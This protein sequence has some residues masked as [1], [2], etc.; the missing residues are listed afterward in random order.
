VPAPAPVPPAPA[1][2][3]PD[4]KLWKQVWS[5]DFDNCPNGRPDPTT[6]GFEHGYVRNKEQQYYQKDNAECDK[7]NLVI[8]AKREQP[9]SGEKGDY[10]SSSLTSENKKVFK[11]GRYEMRAK[12]PVDKGA[13]P[14]FWAR[15]ADTKLEWPSDGE[16]DIMEYYKNTVLANFVYGNQDNTAVW[17]SAKFAL[18]N[19]EWAKE[20]HVWAMEWDAEE[21]RL[22]VDDQL[23]NRQKVAVADDTGHANPW[24]EF[25][26]YLMVNL[27]IGGEN[28]GDPSDT[29]FPLKLYVDYISVYKRMHGT[30]LVVT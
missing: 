6:W 18:P 9:A 24:R 16:I 29:D 26:V 2:S 8:T 28:G 22:F 12:I 20:F 27:A 23:V 25:P 13:W 14:A 1:P 17:N 30:S 5:D 15:G 10:T 4:P 11:N 21:I 19:K 3:P 7:G